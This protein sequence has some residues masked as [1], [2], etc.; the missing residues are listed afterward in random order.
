MLEKKREILKYL[1]VLLAH[2]IY[3][4][5]QQNFDNAY[6]NRI[7]G[8]RAELDFYRRFSNVSDLYSGGYIL[9]KK[10]RQKTLDNPIYFTISCEPVE[11]YTYIY[12]K[13]EKAIF[14]KLFYIEGD[15]VNFK[16]WN[17]EDVMGVGE[18]LPVPKFRVHQFIDEGFV[19]ISTNI[20]SFT[21]EFNDKSRNELKFNFSPSMVEYCEGL[22]LDF[23]IEELLQIY[24]DRL[25]F[26]GYLG[27][28]KFKGI[29]S[30][31][32]S[33]SVKNDNVIFLE[34]KEKDL[35]KRHPIG[36]G[37]DLQRIN[38]IAEISTAFNVDYLYVVKEI[39]NQKIRKFLNWRYIPI[40][41]FIDNIKDNPI[42]N[43]GLGM[44]NIESNPTV[45]C[46]KKYFKI[47]K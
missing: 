7:V 27:F 18:K 25:V 31:I 24:V 36:F 38:D 23:S 44:S 1:N 37:M 20:E 29:A 8:F 2:N 40:A 3:A 13:L 14:Q 33:I 43:G 30:D 26:D 47:L 28:S 34:I 10:Y 41:F 39:N 35:S 32:D 17:F 12:K 19:E 15:N 11:R 21:K 46:E 4:K 42:V 5:T 16:L 9:P 6:K 45:V 22:M